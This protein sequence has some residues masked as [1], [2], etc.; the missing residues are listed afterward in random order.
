[1][2]WFYGTLNYSLMPHFS[3]AAVSPLL[4]IDSG[5][6]AVIADNGFGYGA[7]KTFPTQVPCVFYFTFRK[8]SHGS[9]G[10]DFANK[11]FLFLT[12]VYLKGGLVFRSVSSIA[13]KLRFACGLRSW[14][15]LSL[16]NH[17]AVPLLSADSG[18]TAVIADKHITYEA[19]GRSTMGLKVAQ[20]WVGKVRP[21]AAEH[22]VL[23]SR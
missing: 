12:P 7:V 18:G 6:M 11:R 21:A 3:T 19:V 14:K 20:I 13:L 15:M 17:A 9:C 1:M 8:F 23:H 10:G 5:G 22:G 2:G 16:F 4:S